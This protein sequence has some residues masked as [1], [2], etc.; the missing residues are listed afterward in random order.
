MLRMRRG[1]VVVALLAAVVTTGSGC[2]Y[3]KNVRDDFMDIGGLA[4]GVCT[5]VLE[6]GND[7]T[8]LGF[9]PPSLGVYVQ[10]TD[11]LH[12]GALYK[13]SA[14]ITWDRRGAGIIVD[15]RAKFGVGPYHWITI[16]EL[17]VLANG[18]KTEDSGLGPWREEMANRKDPIF[19]A[20]A[21]IVKYSTKEWQP[22][23]WQGWQDWETFS[24]EVA[25]SEPFITHCGFYARVA[26]DPSQW[27]DAVL[28][29]FFLDLH[30]DRAYN[31]D[32]T[33]RFNPAGIPAV[34]EG[35][36]ELGSLLD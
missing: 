11:F 29:L 31:I 33:L 17:P 28:S 36:G 35:G 26:A 20:P 7:A 13:I 25:I 9:I 5:P 3:F 27:V 6:E 18:Y 1:V 22:Y 8:V 14:D 34:P 4:I 15:E 10:A 12:L 16:R 24:L 23:L 2:G 32:G 19:G 21:K 30:G